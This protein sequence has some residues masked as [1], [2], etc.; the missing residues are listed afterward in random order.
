MVAEEPLGNVHVAKV[1]PG[2]QAD[3]LD[4]FSVSDA[5]LPVSV[6]VLINRLLVV[7]G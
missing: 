4:T 7:L 6:D 2:T 3:A 1:C 5:E